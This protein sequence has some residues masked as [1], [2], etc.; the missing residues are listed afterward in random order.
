MGLVALRACLLNQD[1]VVATVRP[2]TETLHPK[3]LNFYAPHQLGKV[4]GLGLQSRSETCEA[5]W[6][7]VVDLGCVL[8]VLARGM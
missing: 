1:P 2:S 7:A 5:S 4:P 6:V 8:A 3:L